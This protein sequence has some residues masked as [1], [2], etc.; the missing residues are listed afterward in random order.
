MLNFFERAPYVDVLRAP[1]GH[2]PKDRLEVPKRTL[3]D[4][5]VGH[6]V[7]VAASPR[8]VLDGDAKAR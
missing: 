4:A 1:A 6:E 2:Q 3:A 5:E 7:E 8:L